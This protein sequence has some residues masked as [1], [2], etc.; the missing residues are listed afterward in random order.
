MPALRRQTQTLSLR[1]VWSTEQALGQS[2][3]YSKTQLEKKEGRGGG[4]RGERDGG[5]KEN[6]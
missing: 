1:L 2:G 4:R 5:K 6:R 3:L